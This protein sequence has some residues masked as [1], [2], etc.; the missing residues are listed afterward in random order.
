MQGIGSVSAGEIFHIAGYITR[1]AGWSIV[2]DA[3]ETQAYA[4]VASLIADFVDARTAA[5]DEISRRIL[6]P[7]VSASAFKC[8]G[9]AV[10]ADCV[11][12]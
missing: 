10:G 3:V 5:E 1:A 6:K 2:G 12:A 9:S 7:I 11:A 4:K 8:V